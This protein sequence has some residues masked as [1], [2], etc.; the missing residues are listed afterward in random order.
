MRLERL[1][2]FLLAPH[3]DPLDGVVGTDQAAETHGATET[4]EDAELDFRQPDLRF[5]VHHTEVRGQAHFKAATQ[6]LTVDR[7]HCR[8]RQVLNAVEDPVGLEVVVDELFLR[9]REQVGELGDVRA[10]NEGVLGTGNHQ[11]L[12]LLLL[13]EGLGRFAEFLDGELI[14]LVDRLTLQIEVELC[15]TAFD[16]FNRDG[17]TF[18]NHQLFSRL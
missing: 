3:A 5:L 1:V 4:G 16:L 6:C 9:T 14:E 11:A 8:E 15:K 12:E 13:F 18:V 17:F 7:G 10:H 2:R